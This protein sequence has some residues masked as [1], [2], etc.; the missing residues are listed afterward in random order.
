MDW[1]TIRKGYKAWLRLEKGLAEKTVEAYLHDM[2]MLTTYLADCR[3]PVGPLAVTPSDLRNFLVSCTHAGLSARS[4]ARVL[5]GC[6]SL[7]RYMD[8]EKLRTDNPAVLIDTPRIGRTLPEVL[9]VYEVESLMGAVDLSRPEGHRDRAMLETLYGCGLR[10]SELISLKVTNLRFDEGFIRVIGK[11][12]KERMVPVGQKA[13]QHNNIWLK[14]VRRH[15]KVA[16][17]FEDTLYLNRTGRG[18]SRVSVFNIIKTLAQKAGIT[19]S[20]SPHT[21][22]HSFATH[23]VEGGADLRAIQEMLGHE[24]ITTTEIYTH[25]DREYLRET[26]IRYHPRNQKK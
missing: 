12:D 23:L 1:F 18:I 8:T 21:L 11:G 17:G 7:F 15:R 9:T 22:R 20:I 6:K 14:E 13:I 25:L 2:D 3:P 5:S 26:I 24:S 10:V 19:K 4:Q 16:K